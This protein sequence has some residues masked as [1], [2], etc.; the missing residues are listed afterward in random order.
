MSQDNNKN[1]KYQLLWTGMLLYGPK[2]FR[3]KE[4]IGIY[5]NNNF[6]PLFSEKDLHEPNIPEEDKT[7]FFA[8]KKKLFSV[9]LT[10]NSIGDLQVKTQRDF[11]RLHFGKYYDKWGWSEIFD[12]NSSHDKIEFMR[13]NSILNHKGRISGIKRDLINNLLES[14]N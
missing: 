12:M 11:V 5:N 14:G 6:F 10:E 2:M 9:K 1:I 8:L 4:Q 7:C 13:G 3:D